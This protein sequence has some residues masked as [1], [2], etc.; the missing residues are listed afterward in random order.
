MTKAIGWDALKE[1]GKFSTNLQEVIV[2]IYDIQKFCAGYKEGG[3]DFCDSD[4]DG[5]LA[6]FRYA[7]MFLI[8]AVTGGTDALA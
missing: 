7:K 1:N 8:G 6:I 4:S 2:S 3:K 5:L